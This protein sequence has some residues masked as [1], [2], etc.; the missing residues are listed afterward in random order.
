MSAEPELL[1]GLCDCLWLYLTVSRNTNG[2]G[3]YEKILYL[4][5]NS[6]WPSRYFF[7]GRNTISCL[8][9]RTRS[10]SIKGYTCEPSLNASFF[11][12][13]TKLSPPWRKV[14]SYLRYPAPW[15]YRP[16]H[17]HSLKILAWMH[18]RSTA[19]IKVGPVL[20]SAW[21]GKLHKD[22][23]Q[24]GLLIWVGGIHTK[25]EA[26]GLMVF[27]IQRYLTQIIWHTNF[28]GWRRFVGT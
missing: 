5:Q 15:F 24:N 27:S 16:G 11:T 17:V 3:R 20:S 14:M 28:L 13:E 2:A 4:V 12:L 8:R 6:Q 26:N 23:G 18:G 22:L 1:M 19:Y 10:R 9:R 7:D 21:C 25:K